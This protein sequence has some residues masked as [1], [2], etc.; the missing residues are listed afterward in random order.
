MGTLIRLCWLLGSRGIGISRTL[1]SFTEG[2][3]SLAMVNIH[4]KHVHKLGLQP[5]VHVCVPRFPSRLLMIV[6]KLEC[7]SAH[8]TSE[9]LVTQVSIV[10][11]YLRGLVPNNHTAATQCN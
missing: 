7:E 1:H 4:S 2:Y 9:C 8:S 10:L 3:Y 5:H 6:I 11:E